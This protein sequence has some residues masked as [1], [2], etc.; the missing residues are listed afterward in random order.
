MIADMFP[1]IP[2]ADYY[3][4]ILTSNCSLRLQHTVAEQIK[5]CSSFDVLGLS[6]M[7][8]I[9]A[10]RT[11]QPGIWYEFVS[12]RFLG[13]FRC[14]PQTIAR[15]FRDS[16]I[17]YRQYKQTNVYP[18]IKESILDRH[19]LENQRYR[20]RQNT[21]KEGVGEVIYKVILPDHQNVWLKD[22]SSVTHFDEDAICLSPGYLCDVSMEMSQKEYLGEMNETVNRDKNLLVEAERFAALGQISAKIFHEIRNPILSI[23]S[24]AKRLIKKPESENSLKYLDV[25]VKEA[26]RLEDVLANLFRYTSRTSFAPELTDLEALVK[27]VIDLMQ[28]EFDR[29]KITTT[30]SAADALPLVMVDREQLHLAL[31][32][33]LKNSVEA[34]P[35]GGNLVVILKKQ[36]QYLQI[37]IRDSGTGIPAVY[38]R[39]VTEPF[40]TTKV[41]GTGLGLS[42]AQKA[43]GLHDGTLTFLQSDADG[44]EVI[45]ELPVSEP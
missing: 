9:A 10:W 15:S 28:S 26:A 33:I 42:L 41:Y 29:Q 45:V 24:L 30:F 32:H 21:A 13:L 43:I 3:G 20:L 27:S 8:Y 25:I 44:T 36:Q 6:V 2:P 39:R 40:F 17:D 18:D 12:A 35:M 7:P 16:I 1:P 14:N 5:S 22:W 34:M 31:V 37:S 11:D 19:D 38:S 4:Q 23:G